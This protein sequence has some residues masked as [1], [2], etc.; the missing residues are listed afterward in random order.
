MTTTLGGIAIAEKPVVRRGRPPKSGPLNLK[1]AQI[2]AKYPNL[3]KK[4]AMILAGYS[5]GTKPQCVE[6]SRAYES[7]DRQREKALAALKITFQSQLAPL[8]GIRDKSNKY[9]ASDRINAIKTINAMVP[10][11]NAPE[12]KEMNMRALFVELSDI[13]TGD[14]QEMVDNKG[15]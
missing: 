2:R 3:T 10:G 7:V 4:D 1:Y 12:R 9:A 15:S 5:R 6:E 13:T 14:L 8:V 11:F